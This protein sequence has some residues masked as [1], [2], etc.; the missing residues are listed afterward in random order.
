MN[1]LS[2]EVFRKTVLTNYFEYLKSLEGSPLS[3]RI[4]PLVTPLRDIY[5]GE[6]LSG[7]YRRRLCIDVM[8]GITR[9]KT[10]TDLADRLRN[11]SENINSIAASTF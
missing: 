10:P 7:Y 8:N 5:Y 1:G 3:S 6:T 9:P 4:P 11:L 2:K